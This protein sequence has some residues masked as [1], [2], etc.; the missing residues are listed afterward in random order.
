M[1]VKDLKG[2]L[3][4]LAVV[5]VAFVSG[6][7]A[8][9]QVRGAQAAMLA[10]H[11]DILDSTTKQIAELNGV[12]TRV[13]TLLDT[14]ADYARRAERERVKLRETITAIQVNNAKLTAIVEMLVANQRKE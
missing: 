6:V 7:L 12:L 11:S 3:M 4:P 1:S 9:G 8:M 13:V 2:W 14:H 10:N 5:V